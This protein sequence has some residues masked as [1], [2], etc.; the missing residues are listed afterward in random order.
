MHIVG[1]YLTTTRT[2]K[3]KE[4]VT[5]AKQLDLENG[6][7]ERNVRLKEIGLPKETLN[8]YTEWAYGRGKK[9]KTKNAAGPVYKTTNQSDPDS[10]RIKV[11]GNKHGTNV[12]KPYAAPVARHA[13]NDGGCTKKPSQ[14]YTG[15]KIIGIATMHKS[16]MVPIFSDEEAIDVARMRR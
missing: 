9:T 4:N 16:N 10:N 6:W 1:P 15:S 12:D 11:V 14:V 13:I 7:R 3:P 5:K 2:Q 8:Q